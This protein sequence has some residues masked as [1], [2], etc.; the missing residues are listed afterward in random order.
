MSK[1]EIK[2]HKVISQVLEKKISQKRAAE[3]L[4]LSLSRIKVLCSQVR[5]FGEKGVVHGNAGR[6][7]SHAITDEL[8]VEII[9]LYHS[10]YKEFN[11]THFQEK[12]E[13]IHKIVVS[14]PTVYRI[15][16]SSG[17]ISPRKHRKRKHHYRRSPK[18]REG[19]LVQIDASEHDWFG[20]GFKVHLHGAIDDATGRILALQFG[21][22]ETTETY[23]EL[24]LQMN[25]KGQLPLALYSDKRGV[26]TNNRKE[27]DLT[28]E[29]QLAGI[30]PRETQFSRAMDQLGVR[31]VLANS[32]QAT[33][34]IEKLWGTLQDRLI[35]EMAL[36]GIKDIDS[37][38]EFLPSFINQYNRK[39]QREAAVA[40]KAYLDKVPA[41]ELQYI[42]C[43]HHLRKLDRGMSFSYQNRTFVLPHKQN[44]ALLKA[45]P[46]QSITVLESSRFGIRAS[47]VIDGKE[48]IV[49]PNEIA[50]RELETKEE[51]VK[52]PITTEQRSE[53]GKMGKA[54]S[55]WNTYSSY[56]KSRN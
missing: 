15:L 6:K 56:F 53:W 50:K 19:E 27:D 36:A 52:Q 51:E 24:I 1:E 47:L 49:T 11:F 44:R 30:N 4:N 35:N 54:N 26:F 7:P 31:I 42:L 43:S 16:T 14:V 20:N 5:K 32:P 21:E 29:E 12:L 46:S 8:R 13:E 25:K 3:L 33:G 17:L 28:I 23:F 41:K 22:Q 45:Y 9:N 48:L 37:A 2:R 40:E 55:P 18:E 39:F 34:R 10:K 38:N